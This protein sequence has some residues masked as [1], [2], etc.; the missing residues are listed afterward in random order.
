MGRTGECSPSSTSGSFPT[1]SSW[2]RRSASIARWPRRSSRRRSRASFDDHIF[3]HGQSFS[4]H[5]L[6]AAAALASLDVLEEE[7]L[8]ERAASSA[9][10]SASGSSACSRAIRAS[11][12]CAASASSGRSSW[13]PTGQRKSPCGAPPRNTANNRQG[14]VRLPVSREEHLRSLRQVRR[15]G[16]AAA[17]RDEAEFDMLVAAIDDACGSPTT[18]SR[19]TRLELTPPRGTPH[20]REIE[21]AEA[22]DQGAREDAHRRQAGRCGRARRGAQSLHRQASSARCRRP[23]RSRWRRRSRSPTP[24]SPKLTRYDRQKILMRT[25]EILAKRRDEIAA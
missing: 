10:I 8:V 1:S 17:R 19:A 16:G 23:T 5:A 9:P 21:V 15:L 24:T 25:A 7:R 14:R 20:A 3:G 12:T 22:A 6:A 13:S 11:A 18:G 4:G 2:A